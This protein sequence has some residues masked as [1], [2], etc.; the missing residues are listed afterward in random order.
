MIS[1]S[2]DTVG[3]QRVVAR[4]GHGLAAAVAGAGLVIQLGLLF[5]GGSDVN[6]GADSGTIPLGVRLLRFFSYFTIQSNIVVLV[7]AILLA[8]RPAR[9]GT[10]WRIVRLDSLLGIVTTGIVYATILA[11]LV[12][13]EGTAFV[14]TFLLHYLSPWLFLAC[15]IVAGPRPRITWGTVAGAFVWPV[16]WIAYTLI[17]GAITNWYPYPFLNVA[18]LGFPTAFRNIVVILVAAGV[19]AVIFRLLDRLPAFN[20]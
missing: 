6:S 20:R 10:I 8:L 1:A 7:A 2:V 11:P 16:A 17:H 15:W 4:W 14:A 9:D 3:D 19:L 13:L 5:A 18:A 12:H